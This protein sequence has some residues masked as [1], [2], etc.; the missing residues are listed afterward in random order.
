[1]IYR[2]LQEKLN[3]LSDAQLDLQV[4]LID[5]DS[6]KPIRPIDFVVNWRDYD[7]ETELVLLPVAADLLDQD[8]PYLTFAE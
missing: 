7:K 1:M 5:L 3:G 2:E 4:V 6:G 8:H